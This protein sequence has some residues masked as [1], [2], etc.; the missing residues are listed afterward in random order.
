MALVD[1]RKEEDEDA[2]KKERTISVKITSGTEPR[3]RA[4][5]SMD[6][7]MDGV[8]RG[9]ASGPSKG[10]MGTRRKVEM[11]VDA[12]HGEIASMH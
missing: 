6:Y 12:T 8:G 4:G 7:E 11:E 3:P 9:E 1:A 5:T 2:K 10:N